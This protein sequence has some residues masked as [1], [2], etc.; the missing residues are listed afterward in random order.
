MVVAWGRVVG[1]G[2]ERG[3]GEAEAL[4]DSAQSRQPLVGGVGVASDQDQD[5]A[6]VDLDGSQLRR[7]VVDPVQLRISAA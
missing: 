6:A 2:V 1:G 7:G 4:H 3:S 5:G